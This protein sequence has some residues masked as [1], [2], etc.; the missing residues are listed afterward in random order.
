ML[1][2]RISDRDEWSEPHRLHRHS[3]L[4]PVLFFVTDI[5][6][7]TR[8]SSIPC[9]IVGTYSELVSVGTATC[10]KPRSRSMKYSSTAGRQQVTEWMRL[11]LLMTLLESAMTETKKVSYGLHNSCR[12]LLELSSPTQR[13]LWTTFAGER[14]QQTVYNKCRLVPNYVQKCYTLMGLDCAG[15]NM[16]WHEKFS[17]AREDNLGQPLT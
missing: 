12:W 16:L 4:F 15:S 5:S 6:M 8:R 13:P 14:L 3:V 1:P 2:T 10:M 7:S 11:C 9:E 17:L